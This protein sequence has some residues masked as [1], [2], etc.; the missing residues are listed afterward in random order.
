ML[1]EKL[2][3]YNIIL[4]SNSPRRQQFF[5]DLQLSF[6]IKTKGTEEVYPETL[7]GAEISDYLAE[8][9]SK[10][11]NTLNEKDILITSDTIVWHNNKALGK[12]KDIKEATKM[13]SQLSNNTHT[14]ITS[15]CIRTKNQQTIFND[16]TQVTFKKL[17][18]EEIEFYINN[19]SPFD[20]AGS[21]GIQDWIGKIGITNIEGC[22]FNVMGLPIQKL[23]KELMNI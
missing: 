19:F 14:V 23:Y 22:Y 6:S 20:K 9:K 17:S 1:K 16:S 10:A 4:A 5:K 12:P 3:E 15:V 8:L 21:Y 11:F 18:L 2:S 13:L 7:K